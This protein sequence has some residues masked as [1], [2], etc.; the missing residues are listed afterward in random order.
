ME[1]DMNVNKSEHSGWIANETTQNERE[2][3]GEEEMKYCKCVS[4]I[5]CLFNHRICVS[6]FERCT[7][8]PRFF[9]QA[10]GH[11]NR[12]GTQVAGHCID[13]WVYLKQ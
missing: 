3:W 4:K 10:V 9:G 1:F 7:W 6:P 2:I 11:K 12:I 5:K 13:I 8:I